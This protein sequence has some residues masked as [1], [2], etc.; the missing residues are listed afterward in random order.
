[1]PIHHTRGRDAS[2]LYTTT[3]DPYRP[4]TFALWKRSAVL[5]K[6]TY[7]YILRSG[8]LNFF[9]KG[10]FAFLTILRSGRKDIHCCIVYFI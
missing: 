2:H 9:E 3:A 5:Q 8:V 4:G 10:G 1:M 6:R 7:L